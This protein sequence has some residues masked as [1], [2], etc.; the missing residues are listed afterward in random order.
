MFNIHDFLFF[1]SK[2]KDLKT[3]AISNNTI[4]CSIIETIAMYAFLENV[5]RR[6]IIKFVKQD[7]RESEGWSLLFKR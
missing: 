5:R 7:Y 4:T 3:G 2:A 1:N 6:F